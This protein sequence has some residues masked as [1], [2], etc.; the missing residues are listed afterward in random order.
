MKKR[1]VPLIFC[2]ML[3][4]LAQADERPNAGNFKKFNWGLHIQGSA[5]ASGAIFQLNQKPCGHKYTGKLKG[6]E[7]KVKL[8]QAIVMIED[9]GRPGK[10][11]GKGCWSATVEDQQFEY[12]GYQGEFNSDK[13]GGIINMPWSEVFNFDMAG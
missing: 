11:I 13:N 6:V 12:L 7:G 2:A 1:I 4:T 3:T 9:E 8:R 5:S 10:V